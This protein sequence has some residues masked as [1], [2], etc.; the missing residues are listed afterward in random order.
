MT[1]LPLFTLV[2]VLSSEA[3]TEVQFG[4]K[5]LLLDR[6]CR[7]L[8][9]P[10]MGPFVKLGDGRILAADDRHVHV[11][12][13]GGKTWTTHAPFA[14]ADKF[15]CRSER[16][17][18]RTRDGTLVLAFLNLKEMAFRW[19]QAQGGPLAGCRLPV[20]V[21][22]GGDDGRSWEPPQL[23]QDGYCGALRTMIQLRIGRLVLGCQQAVAD[24]G[25]HVCGTYVSDDDGKTWRRSNVIDLGDYGGY[26]DHGGGIEPTLVELRDGRLWMLI[27]TYRGCFT[28]AY[29]HDQGLNWKDI[30]PSKIA[31]S[32]APGQLRR[33][34]SGRLVLFWNRF[35]DPDKRTGRRE[36]LS[37]AFSED[38]GRT[39]SDAVVVAY[40]PMKPGDTEPQHRL[41]YPYVFEAVPGE[42]WVTTMQGPLRIRL[43]EDDFFPRRLSETTYPARRLERAAITVDG[44]AEE[45]Q[46]AEAAVER[47]FAFPW[48]TIDAPTTEFRAV[49]DAS[50]LYFT[51]RVRDEDVVVME[52]L[53]DEED[54]VFEDQVELYFAPDD[55]M[56]NYFAVEIDSRGRAFDYRGAYYRQ[57][58][59]RWNWPGLET[60]ASTL[61]DGYV[62]EGRIPLASFS[63]MGFPKLQPGAKI[64]CGLYRA[65]F[66]HDH[67]GRPVVMKET[68]H[69]RG[70][71]LDGPPPIEAW[72][73]WIDPKTE[74]PDFHVPTSLGL[75]EIVDQPE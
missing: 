26:G 8:G 2:C 65:E 61:K 45:P 73:S 74:E 52:A 53:R 20:Y 60:A 70:R 51:F 12:G 63:E 56:H 32:G 18:L 36:Q 44:Q 29:S 35:I 39:W 27:R 37:V 16:A 7:P 42:L 33:L 50:H 9:S 34:H 6:R 43:F 19:N 47:N 31:A 17:L 64:R 21:T 5:T 66:S 3:W 46:W 23:V 69:N 24:P 62:V 4:S 72:I 30:G 22:R 41:A 67:S 14:D 54:A 15:A 10:L 49:C 71:R 40:D 68:I 55:R 1:W 25:R 13:D 38:D 57:L 11:S 58:D 48:K 75:L 59:P 28:E